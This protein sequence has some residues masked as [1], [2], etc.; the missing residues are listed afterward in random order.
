MTKRGQGFAVNI[1]SDDQQRLALL[2]HFFQHRDHVLD[3]ADLLFEDQDVSVFEDGFHAGAVGD[4]VR[5]QVAAIEL[6][7]FDPLLLGL[8]ALAFVDG[9]HPVLADLAHR[10]G[11]QITDLPIVVAGDGGDIGH[12]RLILHLGSHRVK[13]FRQFL[14]G[15]LNPGLHLDRVDAGNDG[16]EP[17]IEDGFSHHGRGGGSV[18]GHVTG[19]ARD[20]AN[21]AG[22][23][24][25]VDVFQL[26]FFGHGDA[27]FRDG[28]AAETLL[29]DD[30]ASLRTQRD[31]HG[32]SQLGNPAA[33]RFAGFLFKC[34]D[35]CHGILF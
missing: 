28:G 5:R 6:H 3:V 20:F 18:A 2:N 25:L 23:H 1:F 19:L 24:V 10:I 14:D 21:H 9:D 11:Q 7:P 27:V 33:N 15:G 22:A 16:L 31:L 29:Q 13:L 34:N 17:F 4:E 26:N 32:A 8:Q 12:G 35:L 30:V